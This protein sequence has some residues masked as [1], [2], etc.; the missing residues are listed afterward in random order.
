MSGPLHQVGPMRWES[1][2]AEATAHLG[3]LLGELLEE[4]DAVILEG[5]LGAG[6]TQLAKG[7]ARSL[8]VAGEVT[9]PTFNLLVTHGGGRLPLHHLDLY[10]LESEDE[11]GDA[12]AL[13][14]VGVDGA[15]LVE[16]GGPFAEALAPERL[17]I[18]FSRRDAEGSRT[19]E[20]ARLIEF[21]GTGE[22]GLELARSLEAA[23]SAEVRP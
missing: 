19:V 18:S 2:S 12:G 1:A 5:E 9:S 3:E 4:G 17:E 13:D 11:L 23:L 10:R 16:W 14:V 22:R 7:V 6:K 21:S 20:P 15:S 8:G